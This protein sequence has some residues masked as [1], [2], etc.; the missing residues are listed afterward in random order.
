MKLKNL[1]IFEFDNFASSHPLN[2][3]HQSSNYAIY[4]SEQG[5]DYD[6]IGMVDDN[7]KII[8]ASLI[9]IKRINLIYGYGY[10]PKGFLID[11]YNPYIIEEF[12]KLLKKKY[13][14]KN[15][16]FIKINP[17]ISIGEI[18]FKNKSIKYNNNKKIVETLK[19]LNF[20]QLNTNKC[21]DTQ[22]P[23][24]SAV[25]VLKN[26]SL[27]KYSKNT[28]NKINKS[29]KNGLT[30]EKTT[31][32]NMKILYEFIKN[33]KERPIVDYYNYYNSF[34]KRDQMD[35][36]LVKIDFEQCLI[37]TRQKYERELIH[38]NKLTER[39]MLNSNE[40]VLNQKMISDKT[41][42]LYNE[43]IAQATR[44]LAVKKSEYIA[45][46][47]TIKYQNRVNILISGFNQKFKNY[48]PNYFL[49][50]NLIE[51]YKKGFDFLELNGIT[52]S[53]SSENPYKGLNEFKL[54]FNPH[55]FELIGE[56]DLIINEG[57]YKSMEQNGLLAKKFNKK[58][59][60]KN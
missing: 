58:M 52:G 5:Y 17:E 4:K 19:S 57:L 49:H 33:K 21:F 42:S 10:A 31:R 50:H 47:I 8:A 46:A 14:K 51:Y 45:G 28:R 37:N 53:F 41:L 2:S 16:A 12:V 27:A 40:E 23:T 36:F 7:D 30:F 22:L 1:T 55:T 13:Y 24:N 39:M 43:N 38:N 32:D 44:N 60:S 3:Y 15:I 26:A 25:L 18:N 11:Y 29:I 48:N 59:K 35:I 6:L 34:S 9:F 54:G 56:F 20:K